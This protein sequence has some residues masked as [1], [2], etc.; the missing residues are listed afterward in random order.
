MFRLEA[1][2]ANWITEKKQSLI[3]KFNNLRYLK[4]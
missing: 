1:L 2:M 3:D 4:Q